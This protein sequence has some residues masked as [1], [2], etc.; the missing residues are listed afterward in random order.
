M[1]YFHTLYPFLYT[2]CYAID[3]G[4]YFLLTYWL[5]F[6]GDT[7]CRNRLMG[8]VY[9]TTVI[10]ADSMR[11]FYKKSQNDSMQVQVLDL[12]RPYTTC[13]IHDT[14]Y[15]HFQFILYRC[16][17]THIMAVVLFVHMLTVNLKCVST[18]KL[19]N[20]KLVCKQFPN[21]KDSAIFREQ[22]LSGKFI[23]TS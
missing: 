20:G 23:A 15:I 1:Y 16:N 2:R 18:F 13:I 11:I 8:Q 3:F 4:L 5:K 12:Y 10:F 14:T 19:R 7:V 6:V 17:N 21:D 22:T 9:S